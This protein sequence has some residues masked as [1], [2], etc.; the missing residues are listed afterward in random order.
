MHDVV[1]RQKIG[2][3]RHS[4]SPVR[5]DGGRAGGRIPAVVERAD[6]PEHGQE[7][8]AL[9]QAVVVGKNTCEPFP[10]G[11]S[12]RRASRGESVRML[13]RALAGGGGLLGCDAER[14]MAVHGDSSAPG[15]IHD[16][17]VGLAREVFVD[18]DE[19][20][21]IRDQLLH[22]GP[23]LW[24]R[25]HDDW[26]APQRRIAIERGTCAE[27][28][29]WPAK[30][31]FGQLAPDGLGQRKRHVAGSVVHVADTSDAVG[32]EQR[33]VPVLGRDRPERAIQRHVGHRVD[34]HVPQ[35]G[36]E[37][38]AS[39]LH[40]LRVVGHGDLADRADSRDAVAC[41]ENR[42]FRMERPIPDVDNGDAADR[43]CRR[44]RMCAAENE[45]AEN[46]TEVLHVHTHEGH[47]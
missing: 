8:L 28:S 5:L 20:G 23:C 6:V 39:G 16:R 25:A 26:V 44:L 31:P 13:G 21:T 34:V 37:V 27:E 43:D 46:S 18:L 33:E 40:D 29:G 45:Q 24:R 2:G 9:W 4:V 7:L 35:A 14:H 42:L 15:L 11:F 3:D 32:E 36:D 30:N 19:I 47:S 17:E 41:Y 10:L 38:T 12:R 22:R 1:I